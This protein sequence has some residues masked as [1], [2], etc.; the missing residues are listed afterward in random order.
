V[1]SFAPDRITFVITGQVYDGGDEDLACAEYLQDLF[2]GSS[3]DPGP[4]LER[5][6]NSHDAQVFY[7][8]E[9]PLFLESDIGYCTS[10]DRFNFAM[11]ITREDGKLV[12]RCVRP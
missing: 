8:P 5:V 2:C 10:L 6:K 7:N 1:Q 12:M 3:P 9:K 4:F 11:P